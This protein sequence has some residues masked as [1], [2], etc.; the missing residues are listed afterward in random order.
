[1]SNSPSPAYLGANSKALLDLRSI[2]FDITHA[3]FG[4]SKVQ[5]STPPPE[6]TSSLYT[7]LDTWF[8]SLPDPQTYKKMMLPSHIKIQ[9]EYHSTVLMLVQSQSTTIDGVEVLY[10]G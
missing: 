9:L 3:Y 2:M 7:K 5:G 10:E 8:K 4:S 1:M 6:Q